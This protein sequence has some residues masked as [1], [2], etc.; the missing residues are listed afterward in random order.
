MIPAY[1]PMWKMNTF[2]VLKILRVE[3]TPSTLCSL[4]D[5]CNSVAKR[6]LCFYLLKFLLHLLIVNCGI[7]TIGSKTPYQADYSKDDSQGSS[8]FNPCCT[9][10]HFS[11]NMYWIDLL[12]VEKEMMIVQDIL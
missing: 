4:M 11:K 3:T 6:V 12:T 7:P 10:N 8:S 5:D 9:A 2:F 1:I